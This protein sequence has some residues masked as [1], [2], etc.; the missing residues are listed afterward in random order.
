MWSSNPVVQG[1]CLYLNVNFSII[2]FNFKPPKP[3]V[4]IENGTFIRKLSPP[5]LNYVFSEANSPL[6][7]SKS[8]FSGKDLSHLPGLAKCEDRIGTGHILS[9]HK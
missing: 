7:K 4:C 3:D 5:P 6:C 9:L 1:T 2:Y 8:I